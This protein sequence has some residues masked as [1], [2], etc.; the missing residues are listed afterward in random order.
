MLLCN[1]HASGLLTIAAK[2]YY[3]LR[4][5]ASGNRPRGA[6]RRILH[7]HLKLWTFDNTHNQ[8]R[9]AVIVGGGFSHNG[10]NRRHVVIG[11][12]SAQGVRQE[13]LGNGPD[14]L[15]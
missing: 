2:E 13:L 3:N 9:K 10:A 1:D 12:S 7:F 4:T 15:G 14:K 6:L 8:R 5:N 11:D